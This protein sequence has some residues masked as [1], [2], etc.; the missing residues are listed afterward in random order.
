VLGGRSGLGTREPVGDQRLSVVI[1]SYR[2]RDLLADCLASLDAERRLVP[3]RVVVVDNDSRDGTLASLRRDFPWVEAI[4]AGANLGFSRANNLVLAGVRTEFVL[5][6]N[7][8]TVVIPGA[9]AASLDALASRPGIGMLGCKLVKADGSLDHACKRGFPTLLSALG[10][11]SGVGRGGYTAGHLGE[12][13]EGP[14]DA[15]N[16][17]FM[18]VRRSALEAVGLLDEDFWMYGEDLDWCWR[19]WHAGWPVLYWPGATVR[20]LKGGSSGPA[21]TWRTNLEFHRSMAIFYRKHYAADHAA[22]VNVAVQAGIW[23]KLGLSASRSAMRRSI[24]A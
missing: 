22:V 3:M 6:L 15:I 24:A 10:H 21:R 11:F 7:P 20:H 1:V 14:V 23:V 17:A 2:C 13:E 16:G 8:D 9:L 5:L 18:L 19:F 12:D 4:D